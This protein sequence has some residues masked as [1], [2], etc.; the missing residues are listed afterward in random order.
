MN[1]SV[2]DGMVSKGHVDDATPGSLRFLVTAFLSGLLFA[3]GLVLSGMTLPSKIVGF[4]DFSRGLASW[5]PS[6]ALVMAGAMAVYVP[7]W[8]LVKK[9]ER[10]LFDL[11]FHLPT[12]SAIDPKLVTGAL[13]FG[14]GW[15]ISGFCPGPA[16]VSLGALSKAGIPV[17]G[18]MVLGI[19]GFHALEKWR[20]AKAVREAGK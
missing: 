20:G 1:P 12:R 2:T 11:R 15:G 18:G 14:V 6:L 5:D 16:V 19:L 7:V 8:L 9:R 10:P 4:F 13:L 17:V 3:S